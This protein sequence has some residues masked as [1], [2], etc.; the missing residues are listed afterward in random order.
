MGFEPVLVWV[1]FSC[2]VI[3]KQQGKKIRLKGLSR[4]SKKFSYRELKIY[5]FFTD[6]Y[7]PLNTSQRVHSL[8]VESSRCHKK[9]T[10]CF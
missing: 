5:G 8:R 6:L 9:K 7:I 1:Y 10:N 4:P 3:H 2:K